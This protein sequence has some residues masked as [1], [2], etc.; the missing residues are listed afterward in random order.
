[1]KKI[2]KIKAVSAIL[3]TLAG[4][5]ASCNEKEPAPESPF[6]I[7]DE[8]P[9]A[10]TAKAGTYQIA[11]SSNG[12]WTAIV[13]DAENHEW[14]ELTIS[15]DTIVVNVAENPLFTTRSTTVKIT[16]GSLAKSV[17][18]NQKATEKPE[19]FLIVDETPIIATA[20]ADTY[21]IVVSSN[22]E[23]TAVVENAENHEWCRLTINGDTI[24]VHVAENPLFTTR[25][26]TVKI[27][28][29][30]LSKSVM[31]NQEAVFECPIEIKPSIFTFNQG[32]SMLKLDENLKIT[33]DSTY[34]SFYH[35]V[36]KISYQTSIKTPK[37]QWENLT[38]AFNLEIFTKIPAAVPGS[39]LFGSPVGSFSV[40]I[41]GEIYSIYNPAFDSKYAK[42]MQDFFN[43][44]QDFFNL[45]RVFFYW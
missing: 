31:V 11:I 3:L 25:S 12:E 2:L 39:S 26:A 21:H 24:V 33:A 34:Y 37:E 41:N 7:V 23:W 5:L 22:G 19:P 9:I 32:S 15:G 8:T 4:G 35:G 45:V 10:A 29:E 20:E 36:E 40:F 6:L 28:L 44:M 43:L 13:E 17:V 38:R 18:I 27:T 1:M 42:Q 16:L 14:C 30:N